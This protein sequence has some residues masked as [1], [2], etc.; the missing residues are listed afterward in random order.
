MPF[1]Y[2]VGKNY[3]ISKLSFCKKKLYL[4]L[5]VNFIPQQIYNKSKRTKKLPSNIQNALNFY[6]FSICKS[7]SSSLKWWKVVF[8]SFTQGFNTKISKLPIHTNQYILFEKILVSYKKHMF[9]CN[10]RH[11]MI[12][13]LLDRKFISC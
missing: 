13:F 2:R 5:S 6:N 10:R 7:F 8:K 3:Q 4:S 9:L 12:L 11:K 1:Q